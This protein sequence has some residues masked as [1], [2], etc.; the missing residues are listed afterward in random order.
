M[1]KI[2]KEEILDQIKSCFERH[3][4]V[5]R[6]IFNEDSEYCSGKTVYNKFGSFSSA[7][8]EAEVPHN[9]KPQKKEKVTVNCKNCGSEK[10]VYPYR[11]SVNENNRF[12]CDNK[13]QG[14]WWSTNLT[15][16]EHP[17]YL[18]GGDWSDKMGSMWHNKRETCLDRDGYKCRVC[19]ITQAEHVDEF[20]FG[21]DVHH[22]VPRRKF[23]KDDD[24]SIDEAN[25]MDN[26]VTLCRKHHTKVESGEMEVEV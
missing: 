8:E 13:C 20:G 16:E 19:E 11:L 18:G 21:L 5:N 14:E 10:K 17:L 23:Y 3:G 26:L 15:G 25:K 24:R 9:D 4:K 12:F 22:I 7:C 1:R 6:R 2:T